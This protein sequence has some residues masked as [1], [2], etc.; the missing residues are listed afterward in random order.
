M[1][2]LVNFLTS[3]IGRK[4]VMSLTGL[5]LCLF[6]TIHLI[7]NLQLFVNDNGL[8]FNAYAEFMA[9]NK[10]IKVASILTMATII[11]H[12]VQ[13]ILLALKNRAARKV[14]YKVANKKSSSWSSRNMAFLG[15]VILVFIVTHLQNFWYQMKFGAV[16]E[17]AEGNKNLYE[18]VSVAFQQEWLVGLYVISMVAIAYHL[19]HGFESGFQSLGLNHKKYAPILKFLSIGVFGILVPLL[20]ASMPIFFYIKGM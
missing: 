9:H 15:V 11:L 2:W 7:G 16:P 19:V 17:D 3:S 13:G 14:G 20:F 4:L 1:N 5:F 6:L 10:L 18:V 12:A 8:T